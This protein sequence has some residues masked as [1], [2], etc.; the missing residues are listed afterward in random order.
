MNLFDP[1]KKMIGINRMKENK[2]KLFFILF[3]GLITIL[4]GFTMFHELKHGDFPAHIEFA[5]YFS[6]HGYL[7]KIPHTLF[8][9]LVTIIRALLPANILVWISPLAKQIYDLKAFEISTLILMVLC[10]IWLSIIILKRLIKEYCENSNRILLFIGVLTLTIIL[11]API[12]FFTFPDRMF[13]GYVNGNRYDSPTYILS[14]PFV[15]LV[16][17]GIIDNLENK[18]NWKKALPIAISII[19]A[20]LAK[21][22]FTITIFPAIGLLLLFYYLKDL[23]RV[24]WLFLIFS[25]GI[26]SAI[27]LFGQFIIN[28]TGARGD[29]IGIAPFKEILFHVPNIYLVFFFILMSITFP[30]LL[31]V[32]YWKEVCKLLEFRLAWINYIIGQLY[33]LI[34]IEEINFGVANFW[35]SAMIGN[36]ILFFSTI[37]FFGKDIVDTIT[38]RQ[39][40]TNKQIILLFLLGLHLVCGVIYLIATIMNQ[41]V[42]VE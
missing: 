37:K 4:F 7:Y 14:K 23:K 24:N 32:F 22:S 31:T 36:F 41:G 21:P 12:F 11:V 25:L 28:Y 6:E 39:K 30:L 35:N 10:Y 26:P 42:N 29:S 40:L 9:R 33:G 2:K 20:T 38:N 17:L 13:S 5:R 15:L 1:I 27:V 34:F 18:W 16:F 8:A 3:F 19:C